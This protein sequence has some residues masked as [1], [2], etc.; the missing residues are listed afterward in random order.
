MKKVQVKP[1][2]RI[3]AYEIVSRAVE[4]GV[5]YGYNRA[6]KHTDK[7]TEDSLK[8]EIENAVMNELSEVLIYGD[9]E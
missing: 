2:I 8:A 6:H 5:A 7:P 9:E 4:D 3:N 1:Y